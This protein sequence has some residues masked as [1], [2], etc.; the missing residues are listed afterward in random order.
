[1]KFL[2]CVFLLIIAFVN[3]QVSVT[4]D[5]K[6]YEACTSTTV[7]VTWNGYHNVQETTQ[8]GYSSCSTSEY[9]G[10]EIVTYNYASHKETLN[11]GA[12]EGTTRYFVCGLH[13]SSNKKFKIHCSSSETDSDDSLV[14]TTASPTS[15]TSPTTST[16]PTS[17]TTTKQITPSNA[18]H[19]TLSV[20]QLFLPLFVMTLFLIHI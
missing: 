19:T 9:I 14:T 3:G 1:M 2:V 5:N 15:P 8:S 18:L 13:C 6:Q 11:I 10:A 4:F 12:S 16:S 17:P 7:E 20:V